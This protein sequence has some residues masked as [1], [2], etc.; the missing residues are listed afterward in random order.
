MTDEENFSGGV[1]S[2]IPFQ[3]QQQT[4][5]EIRAIYSDECQKCGVCCL[6]YNQR[7]FGIGTGYSEVGIPKRWVQVG[8]HQDCNNG[9]NRYLRIVPNQDKV[10]NGHQ[11]FN[12]CIALQ[13]KARQNVSCSI[14]SNRPKCCS[15]FDPGSLA[16]IASRE[17]ADM[18]HP[19]SIMHLGRS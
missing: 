12:R 3:Q 4:Q 19:Y 2:F 7:P 8:P 11:H 15:N 13:G 18:E 9:Q 17:W 5:E 14:Y 1:R 16:C 10:F 6:V